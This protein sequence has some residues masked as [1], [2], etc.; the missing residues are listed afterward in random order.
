MNYKE[1]HVYI[2]Q[3]REMTS[4]DSWTDFEIMHQFDTAIRTRVEILTV[5]NTGYI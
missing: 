1:G 2:L 3:C 5:A 4:L